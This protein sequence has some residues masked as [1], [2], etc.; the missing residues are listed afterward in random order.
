MRKGWHLPC[1]PFFPGLNYE[2]LLVNSPGRHL[3]AYAG[4][5]CF[6]TQIPYPYPCMI[7]LLFPFL[8][9]FLY[10]GNNGVLE[11]TC[12]AVFGLIYEDTITCN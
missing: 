7:L 3:G 4:Q 11:T 12:L 5:A 8:F 10:N 1:F 2:L 9:L 6:G